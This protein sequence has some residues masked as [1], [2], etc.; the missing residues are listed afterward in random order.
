MPDDVVEALQEHRERLILQQH[1]GLETGLVFPSQAGTPRM[2]GSLR[3]AIA[4]IIEDEQVEITK[5]VSPQVLR[6]TWVSRMSDSGVDERVGRSICGHADEEMTDHYY[7]ATREE[8]EA[9]L[10]RMFL[11]SQGGEAKG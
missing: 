2:A 11:R 3:K 4:S 1:R 10:A 7:E 6:K 9:A 8:Q 5:H